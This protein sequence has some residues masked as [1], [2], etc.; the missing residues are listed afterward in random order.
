MELK[1]CQDNQFCQIVIDILGSHRGTHDDTKDI[2]ISVSRKVVI[3][4]VLKTKD[5]RMVTFSTKVVR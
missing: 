3:Q 4:V 2:V 5:L 1:I